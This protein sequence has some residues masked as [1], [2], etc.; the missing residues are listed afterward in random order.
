M[1]GKDVIQEPFLSEGG[2]A[3]LL[4]SMYV[5]QQPCLD[6]FLPRQAHAHRDERRYRHS[7]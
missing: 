6:L 1:E 7:V 4:N 2:A 5:A 3:A